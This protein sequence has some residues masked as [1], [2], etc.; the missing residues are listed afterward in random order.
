MLLSSQSLQRKLGRRKKETVWTHI[1][2]TQEET[3]SKCYYQAYR[4]TSVKLMINNC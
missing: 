4:Y 1:Q 3:V 2:R